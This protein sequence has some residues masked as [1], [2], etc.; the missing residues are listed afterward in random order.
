MATIPR[1]TSKHYTVRKVPAPIHLDES[2]VAAIRKALAPKIKG[3]QKHVDTSLSGIQRDFDS[4]FEAVQALV[5][6]R[7]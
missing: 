2:A 3:L 1:C 4:K 6:P 7:F 5:T